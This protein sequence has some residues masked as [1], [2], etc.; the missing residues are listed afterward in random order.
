MIEWKE[1]APRFLYAVGYTPESAE[2][3]AVLDWLEDG[4]LKK[5]VT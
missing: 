3:G 2:C 5:I 4:A 1:I